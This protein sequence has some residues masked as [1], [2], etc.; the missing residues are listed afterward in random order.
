MCYAF[1]E[2]R[3]IRCRQCEKY[4]LEDLLY[5]VNLR[6]YYHEAL[7][8]QA[9]RLGWH[10]VAVDIDQ[11][12]ENN[13]KNL[14][15]GH[16]ETTPHNVE[17]R[18]SQRLAHLE[19]DK[20]RALG[21][22]NA[23]S[24]SRELFNVGLRMYDYEALIIFADEAAKTISADYHSFDDLAREFL[25]DMRNVWSD[26]LD[27]D[28]VIEKNFGFLATWAS[29]ATGASRVFQLGAKSRSSAVVCLTCR[30][31]YCKTCA[32][33]SS[34]CSVCQGASLYDEELRM[35]LLLP[36]EETANDTPTHHPGLDA[37]HFERL[38]MELMEGNDRKPR[39]AL[40]EGMARGRQ[41]PPK[42]AKLVPLLCFEY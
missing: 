9:E 41:P 21:V 3:P 15:A 36:P 34:I 18:G 40:D 10:S 8:V 5:D 39:Y 16:F 19:K 42:R 31:R 33:T 12:V 4:H 23:H 25:D 32:P 22:E 37:A 13:A 29:D 28:Y 20:R 6:K 14:M 35:L 7:I 38:R 17:Q 26:S 2:Q 30:T 24:F 1:S 27:I 11:F